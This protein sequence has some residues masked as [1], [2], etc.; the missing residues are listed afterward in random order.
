MCIC[1][2][3]AKDHEDVFVYPS[4][5]KVGWPPS[6][7]LFSCNIEIDLKNGFAIVAPWGLSS[8]VE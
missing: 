3:S 8:W 1:I 4:K 6:T 5:T 2:S 7:E